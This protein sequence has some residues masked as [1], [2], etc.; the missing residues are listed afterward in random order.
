MSWEDEETSNWDNMT[1][2]HD[3]HWG[4]ESNK[5]EINH[6]L[7]AASLPILP[8]LPPHV[9]LALERGLDLEVHTPLAPEDIARA[10][11][12]AKIAMDSS[13]VRAAML[14]DE[15]FDAALSAA[16]AIGTAAQDAVGT[17]G[18]GAGLGVTDFG[19]AAG[20]TA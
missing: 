11:T 12:R 16:L 3:M 1:L 2:E 15:G 5:A 17:S 13:L 18:L 10:V 20:T 8:Y 14:F 4:R 9:R 19:A 7:V 6:S